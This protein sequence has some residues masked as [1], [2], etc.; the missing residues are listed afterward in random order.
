MPLYENA[1][2][3]IL[4]LFYTSILYSMPVFFA[5]QS[6]NT[7]L[8]SANTQQQ[9]VKQQQKEWLSGNTEKPL[10]GSIRWQQLLTMYLWVEVVLAKG[11]SS[12]RNSYK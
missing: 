8:N 2:T 9:E 12:T 6:F 3:E 5:Y 1:S 4:L 7:A 10:R 11:T